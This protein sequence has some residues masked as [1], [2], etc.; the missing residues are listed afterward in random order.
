MSKEN[1]LVKSGQIRTGDKVS[2]V[3]KGRKQSHTVANVLNSGSK[4][5]EE[6]ILNSQRNV[7]FITQ[8]AINGSSWAK[9]VMFIAVEG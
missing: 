6:I 7:Y 4:E 8:M 2:L 5:K 9:D 1:R 3:F